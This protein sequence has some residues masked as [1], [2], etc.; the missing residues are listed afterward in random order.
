M[1]KLRIPIDLMIIEYYA[2]D[3]LPAVAERWNIN[4]H[5]L[6]S[7]FKNAGVM[8]RSPSL[9][10]KGIPNR[11]RLSA[12]NRGVRR[13]TGGVRLYQSREHMGPSVPFAHLNS[14]DMAK[15]ENYLNNFDQYDWLMKHDGDGCYQSGKRSHIRLPVALSIV[16]MSGMTSSVRARWDGW[17]GENELDEIRMASPC[18]RT[19]DGKNWTVFR[20]RKQRP[21]VQNREQ[22]RTWWMK[23]VAG[24]LR[25]AGLLT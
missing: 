15:L 21:K 6:R 5:T 14:R 18:M 7:R 4:I 11:A 22:R 17:H 24:D 13:S 1:R 3:S 8:M 20:P 19:L 10:R 12:G 25:E 9:S 16:V 23:E 2:G